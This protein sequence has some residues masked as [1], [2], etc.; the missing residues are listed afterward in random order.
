MSFLYELTFLFFYVMFGCN[1]MS[2]LHQGSLSCRLTAIEMLIFIKIMTD[3]LW[4]VNVGII[5]GP[6]AEQRPFI[7]LVLDR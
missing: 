1:L 2:L 4:E 6:N 3:F 5:K 7:P